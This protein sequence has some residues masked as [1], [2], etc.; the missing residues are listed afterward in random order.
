MVTILWKAY[1]SLE[2]NWWQELLHKNT[3][4]HSLSQKFGCSTLVNMGFESYFTYIVHFL[5]AMITH[6]QY[7]YLWWEVGQLQ[8]RNTCLATSGIP[9]PNHILF[10]FLITIKAMIKKFTI[11]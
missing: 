6:V 9:I 5:K 8:Y 4:I 10:E 11:E 1:I 2:Q 7:D 3:L